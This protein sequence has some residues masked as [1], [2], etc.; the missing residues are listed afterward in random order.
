MEKKIVHF[1]AGLALPVSSAVSN[2]HVLLS[3]LGLQI[4]LH[5]EADTAARLNIM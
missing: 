1:G 2:T 3:L 5:C 4:P